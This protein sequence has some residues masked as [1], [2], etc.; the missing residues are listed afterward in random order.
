MTEEL[1][2]I[3]RK[4][5][6]SSGDGKFSVFLLEEKERNTENLPSPL[7]NIIFLTMP[8]SSSVMFFLLYIW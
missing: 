4:I 2:G 1:K 6:F 7:E 3:V 8:F 5:I